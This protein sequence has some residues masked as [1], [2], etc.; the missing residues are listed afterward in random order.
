[1]KRLLALAIAL[2]ACA[3]CVTEVRDTRGDVLN[4][5]LLTL[6]AL[7]EKVNANNA[8]LPTLWARG[9]IDAAIVE[10]PGAPARILNG[11]V[12]V[13]HR[14]PDQLL[15]KAEKDLVDD[16]FEL[17]TD[18]ERLWLWLPTEDIAYV[19]EVGRIDPQAAARLPLRPDLV[20][21]V[22]GIGLIGED[23]Q[24]FPAPLLEV[25]P[26]AETYMVRFVEPAASGPWL[27]VAKQVEYLIPDDPADLPLPAKVILS[28]DDGRPVL[29]ARLSNH[30]EIEGGATVATRFRLFFP[31]TGTKMRIEL[32]VLELRRG[33][34]IRAVPS[35]AS[36]NFDP[37]RRG[38]DRV[39]D[40]GRPIEE[41]SPDR[42]A[43]PR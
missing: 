33:R 27:K 5:P 13:L 18:G 15:L 38:A 24:A 1:V 7:V 2:A 12:F 25:N 4:R 43:R 9:Y 32:D 34:G 17:G 29:V 30:R 26:D 8:K 40:L 35:A 6:P 39:I 11:S 28:D 19:G 23:L 36:F 42:S 3:G 22:L 41:Q 10:E 31:E 21:Q 14:K 20:L 37:Q 16:L